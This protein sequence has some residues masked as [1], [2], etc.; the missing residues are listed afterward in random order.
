MEIIDSEIMDVINSMDSNH[1][2]VI[3]DTEKIDSNP[4]IIKDTEKMDSNPNVVK[5]SADVKEVLKEVLNMEEITAEPKDRNVADV[6]VEEECPKYDSED[7]INEYI[8]S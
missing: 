5:E 8:N 3:K 2:I 6:N 1:P 7:L 4:I